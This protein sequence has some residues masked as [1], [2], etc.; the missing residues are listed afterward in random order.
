M[1]FTRHRPSNRFKAVP[2]CVCLS[3]LLAS[4]AT[5]AARPFF[6]DDARIVDHKAC[7]IES[8][9]LSGRDSTEYRVL[10]ACNFTGNLELTLGGARTSYD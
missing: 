7:Q 9:I 4:P 1:C 6:T 10:P 2:L 8:G 3:G 5:Y